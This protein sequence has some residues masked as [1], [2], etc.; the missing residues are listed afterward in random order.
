MLEK[1]VEKK[2][3]EKSF[4]KKNFGKINSKTKI[5]TLDLGLSA[6]DAGSC[7]IF[8]LAVR[9]PPSCIEIYYFLIDEFLFL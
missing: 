7:C 5:H 2:I 9:Q 8:T 3:Y 6:S 1:N 4:D